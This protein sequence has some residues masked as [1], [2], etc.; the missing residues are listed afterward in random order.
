MASASSTSTR[1]LARIAA[2]PRARRLMRQLGIDPQSV[3]GTGPGGRIVEADLKAA[4][5]KPAQALLPKSTAAPGAGSGISIMRRAIAEKTALS[6]STAPHFYLRREADATSLVELRE[7]LVPVI[8]RE[9][10]VKLTLTDLLV[11]AMA[12]TLPE[13]PYAN[14]IWQH[15]TLV[16]LP[17]IDIGIVVGLPDGLLIPILRN[18]DRLTLAQLARQRSDLADA[19]RAGKLSAE[20]MQGGATSLSNLGAGPVDEFAAVIAPPHSSMLAAGRA[21]PRPFVVEGKLAVRTTLRLCLSVDHRVMDGSPAA[22][23][24]GRIVDLLEHPKLLVGEN[25]SEAS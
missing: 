12:R 1:G 14:C 8:E 3:R 17:S 13:F 24:L 11:C 25:L 23:W 7:K 4:K 16:K 5:P 18:A 19:A 2:S 10:G 22:Q 21:A 6:F 15:N 9:V 20:A